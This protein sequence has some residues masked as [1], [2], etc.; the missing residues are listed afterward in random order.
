MVGVCIHGYVRCCRQCVSSTLYARHVGNS[1]VIIYTVTLEVFLLQ[2]RV[3]TPQVKSLGEFSWEL[4][5]YR[6]FVFCYVSMRKIW[7]K[8]DYA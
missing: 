3:T 4:S 8:I 1:Q 6:Y 7:F 5:N 2:C